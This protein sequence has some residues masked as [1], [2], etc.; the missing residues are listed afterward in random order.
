MSK[1]L[2][3]IATSL[4]KFQIAIG[5][6]TLKNSSGNLL[7]R[8]PADSADAAV[9]ASQLNN[10]GDAIVIN[11]DAASTGT[12]WALTIGR[13]PAATAAVTLYAPPAKGTDGFFLRQKAGTA[14]GVLELELAS[15][16][17]AS[18]Q[19]TTDTTSLAFGTT[20]P[21][22]LFTLPANAV[23]E[24]VRVIIDTPF[25]GGTP[26]LSVGITGTTSK[27]MSSTQVDLTAT[28]QTIFEVYPGRTANGSSENLIAT[29]AANSASAGAA[30]IEVDYAIPS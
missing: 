10:S 23:V 4:S 5:G 17:G 18:N 25:T 14:A 12:D 11:S 26:S 2:D 15:T 19:L 1:V 24:A 28:A 13:N 6:V 16:S 22:T 20:S 29:Y 3:V 8:N 30:R 7:V 27:Y 9:T 21:L